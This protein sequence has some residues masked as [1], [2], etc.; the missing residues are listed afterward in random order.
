M[1]ICDRC[2]RSN[3][4]IRTVTVCNPWHN[5]AGRGVAGVAGVPGTALVC[6]DLCFDCCD[7]VW[8]KMKAELAVKEVRA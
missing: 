5:C 1:L 2:D 6:L 3:I 4:A 8:L 7:T